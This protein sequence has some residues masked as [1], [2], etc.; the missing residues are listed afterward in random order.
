M[1]LL[2]ALVLAATLAQAQAGALAPGHAGARLSFAVIGDTPYSNGEE[3]IFADM[4]KDIDREELAFVV[5]IGDFKSSSSPCTDELFARRL[6]QFQSARHAFIYVPGDNEWTDCHRSGADPLERLS[7]LREMFYPDEHSLGESKLKLERQSADARFAEYRE[8]VRWS[9][10]QVLFIGLNL[11]GSNN[12]SGRTARMDAEYARRGA[13][14]AAWLAQGFDLA[15]SSGYS[16]VFIAAQANP[17]FER[18]LRRP[19]DATDGYAQFRQQL[20]AHTLDFG[21]PVILIH[22]DSHRYRVDHPLVDPATQQTVENFTRIETYGSPWVE[23]LRV[24]VDPADPRTLAIK[25]GKE[26]N[27]A[28]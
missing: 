6:R 26:I 22:G 17:R 1:R 7:K 14:N 28:Q 24:S 9:M 13:A 12:N 19:A 4:L 16:A 3:W 20:L 15:K 23:W 18:P 2:A 5:H 11:P 27:P 8:N 25:T 21:K 10:G